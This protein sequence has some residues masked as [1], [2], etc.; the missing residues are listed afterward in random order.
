VRVC[1]NE[2]YSHLGSSLRRELAVEDDDGALGD[3]TRQLVTVVPEELVQDG[4]LR[5]EVLGA[6]DVP[7]LVL[8][9]VARVNDHALLDDVRV[10]TAQHV[11]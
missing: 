1:L 3:V 2:Y 10:A 6:R 7:A 8:V 9:R 11:P 4:V 5:V